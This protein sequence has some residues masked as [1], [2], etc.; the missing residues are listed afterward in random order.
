VVFSDASPERSGLVLAARREA[1]ASLHLATL[2]ELDRDLPAGF[3]A[4][5][6]A[7]VGFDRQLVGALSERYE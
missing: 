5:R 3:F 6:A 2:V 7:Q 4:D 1:P